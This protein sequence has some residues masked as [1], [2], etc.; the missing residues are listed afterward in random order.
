MSHW[1]HGQV[2]KAYT[3]AWNRFYF[4]SQLHQY[5]GSVTF[6]KLL[7]LSESISSP[8]KQER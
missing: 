2:E 3:L 7:N 6:R 5:T 8:V 4:K 1:H